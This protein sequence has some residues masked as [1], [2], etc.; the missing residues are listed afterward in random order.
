[1]AHRARLTGG[2]VGAEHDDDVAGRRTVAAVV[3]C[4]PALS[5]NR[6][7]SPAYPRAA[8]KRRRAAT[9][10]AISTIEVQSPTFRRA[11]KPAE[12]SLF[13][14]L[15]HRRTARARCSHPSRAT[16]GA[17]SACRAGWRPLRRH[18]RV[19]CRSRER[20]L[21]GDQQTAY[22]SRPDPR[23]PHHNAP[24]RAIGSDELVAN[25]RAASSS[26]PPPTISPDPPS[27]LDAHL[28][29]DDARPAPRRA[30]LTQ[31]AVSLTPASSPPH[32]PSPRLPLQQGRDQEQKRRP[33]TGPAQ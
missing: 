11:A 23:R 28:V 10:R 9:G 5:P 27:Y 25:T 33:A 4:A 19:I 20:G 24:P 7:I 21:S 30:E 1:M 15:T 14:D 31:S 26:T 32:N 29:A 16:G 12:C 13:P 17:R 6:G 22:P 18:Q 3:C 8:T 2:P